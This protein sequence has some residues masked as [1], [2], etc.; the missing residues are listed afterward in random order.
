MRWVMGILGMLFAMSAM[1]QDIPKSVVAKVNR[2]AQKYIDDISVLIDGFGAEGA[3]DRA[4]LENV[5]AMARAEGR[6]L[7]FRRLQGADLNGDG[8]IAF[9][10]MQVTAAAASAV[11][12][13]RLILYF[14]KAD[15]D[16]DSQVTAPELQ[17]YANSV[18][19]ETFS[20]QKAQAMFAILTFDGDAD[21][22]VTKAE[23]AAGVGAL[24]LASGQTR[25]IQNQ[26]QIQRDD[27][28]SDHD[29]QPDQPERGHQIAH[30]SVI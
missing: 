6:A 1:A 5:V 10:E 23:V 21:G 7:A 13:G 28:G 15:Q 4:G 14:G 26:L 8:A 16:G 9:S 30:F 19:L 20:A 24:A 27:D 18:A 3:I 22:R 11:S 17:S 25:E 12:R 29:S 2:D